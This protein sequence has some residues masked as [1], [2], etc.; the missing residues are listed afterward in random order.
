MSRLKL[1]DKVIWRGAWGKQAPKEV[2]VKQ[3]HLCR[4]F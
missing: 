1:E 3:I 2:I 4:W